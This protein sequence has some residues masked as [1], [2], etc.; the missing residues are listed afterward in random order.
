[1]TGAID[2]WCSFVRQGWFAANRAVHW[3]SMPV[4]FLLGW[5]AAAA[6]ELGNVTNRRHWRTVTP[7]RVTKATDA[8]R[9]DI[10]TNGL[11]V[12]VPALVRSRAEARML[13]RCVEQIKDIVVVVVVD[14]GSPHPIAI[15][16][17]NVV[18]HEMN[19]GPAAARNTGMATAFRNGGA[20]HVAFTDVDCVPDSA[21]VAQHAKLQELSPGL[22]SGVTRALHHHKQHNFAWDVV[23]RFHDAVGTLSPRVF[24]QQPELAVYAPT[25]NLSVSKNVWLDGVAFDERYPTSAFEDVDFCIRAR[26]S[27]FPVQVSEDAVMWHDF[28]ASVLGLLRSY[29]K[30]GGG[31]ALVLEAHGNDYYYNELQRSEP[32]LV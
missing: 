26:A 10:G 14:D 5:C 8:P 24:L 18:R 23:S 32:L 20:R 4:F 2:A 22:W 9:C 31:L 1:M 19:L 6:F 25:C 11:V 13:E 30:Y 12:V 28:D 29:Y 27:G 7:P 17:V 3:T 15:P 21:W 16:G